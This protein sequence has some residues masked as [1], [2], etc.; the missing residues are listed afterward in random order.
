MSVTIQ[1]S[2]QIVAFVKQENHS[3]TCSCPG[4]HERKKLSAER[5]FARLMSTWTTA[6][7]NS[8]NNFTRNSKS[9]TE[10]FQSIGA[11]Q[12]VKIVPIFS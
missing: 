2:F 12:S 8:A 1:D 7:K 11:Y 3:R 6:P 5:P 4:C 9:L 10:V